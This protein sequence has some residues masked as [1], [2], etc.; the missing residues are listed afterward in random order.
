M[1]THPRKLK[2]FLADLIHD[3]YAYNYCAPLNIGYLAATLEQRFGDAIDLSLHK[4]PKELFK[5]LD[6]KPDILALS[7]YDW[8]INL[9]RSLIQM[10][11]TRNPDVFIVMGGPNIRR[12]NKGTEDFLSERPDIDAYVLYE[13]EEAFANIVEHMIGHENTLHK[14]LIEQ[15]VILP[16][17][18]YMKPNNEGLAVGPLLPSLSSKDIPHPSAWL[19]GYMDPYLNNT[20]FPLSPIIETTRGCPYSCTYCTAW[21]TAATGIKFIR[22]FSLDVVYEELEYIFKNS[23]QSFYLIIGDANIGILDRDLEIAQRIRDLRD[24]YGKVTSVGL[25]TSKNNIKRNVEVYKILGDLS[26]PTFAQQTFNDD[27][28]VNIGRKNVPFK[29]TLKLVEDVHSNGGQISTDLLIGLPGESKERHVDSVRAAFKAGFDKFQVGDIRLLLG[30]EMEEDLQRDLYGIE[31]KYRIIPNSFG[32]YGGERVID[33]ENCIRKTND[34]SAIDFQE[35]RLFHGNI[36]VMLNLEIGRPLLEIANRHGWHQVDLLWAISLL[37]DPG[38]FPDLAKHYEW[39]VAQSEVEWFDSQEEA[40]AYYTTDENWKT[41]NSDGFPKL[42]YEHASRLISNPVLR[43]QFLKYG[44][45]KI[46][47]QLP[48]LDPVVVDGVADFTNARVVGYP[49]LEHEIILFVPAEVLHEVGSIVKGYS[50]NLDRKEKQRV[51]LTLETE[52]FNAIVES[53]KNNEKARSDLHAIQ[54][55]IQFH[56][57]CFV[58]SAELLGGADQKS[59]RNAA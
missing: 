12:G 2:V 8:N 9:N 4:F 52:E 10:A 23:K 5:C 57:K 3:Q 27:I 48:D 25:D 6:E 37:P 24:Q 49:V 19:S 33:Y 44:A 46:K 59:G 30:T 50:A 54:M 32:E 13:G 41:L 21:G 58:R 22:K 34:M 47:Q 29:D 18:A 43:E 40:D 15:G 53:T 7:N 56:N 28:S 36:F 45:E 16:Q 1:Y 11:R 20:A 42:N 26:I 14:S 39:Y 38:R 55:L 17:V 51:R 31:T 35:L